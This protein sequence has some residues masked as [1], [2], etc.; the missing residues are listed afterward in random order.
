MCMC[1]W[2]PLYHMFIPIQKDWQSSVLKRFCLVLRALIPAFSSPESFRQG[3]QR[4]GRK[5]I[6]LYSLFSF[7]LSHKP[8][9]LLQHIAVQNAARI[10]TVKRKRIRSRWCLCRK[11][12]SPCSRLGFSH[13]APLCLH[14]Y[15]IHQAPVALGLLSLSKYTSL[16][17]QMVRNHSCW[18]LPML[19]WWSLAAMVVSS[20]VVFTAS[21]SPTE[22]SPSQS[23]KA[24]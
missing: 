23:T 22:L 17:F 10:A 18:Y 3:S 15:S 14:T 1:T 11:G 19:T 13:F 2:R 21:R 8:H 24:A 12:T 7:L 16:T 4:K 6:I 9:I 20:S 5:S